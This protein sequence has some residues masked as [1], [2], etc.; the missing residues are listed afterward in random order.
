MEGN[1][2][3]IAILIGVWATFALDVFSTLNSSPQTT[4]LNA[5][6][7]TPSLMYWV[8]IGAVVAVAGGGIASVV[9]RKVWPLLVT[10]SVAGGMWL[11]YMHATKRG[12]ANP[13]PTEDY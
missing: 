8:C 3:S 2:V 11:L 7:R 9:S 4:E 12:L 13:Q 5:G 10:A 6:A 1:G